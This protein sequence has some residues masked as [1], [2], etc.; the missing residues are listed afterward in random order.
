MSGTQAWG[1]GGETVEPIATSDRGAWGR[2][3]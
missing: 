2:L 1:P 3:T